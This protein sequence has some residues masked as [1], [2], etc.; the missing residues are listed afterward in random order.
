M[1]QDQL[2]VA[3]TVSDA[4]PAGHISQAFILCAPASCEYVPARHGTHV[5]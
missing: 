4:F 2:F 5:V 1:L 3:A